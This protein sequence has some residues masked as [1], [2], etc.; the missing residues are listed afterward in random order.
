[1]EKT[2]V[3][4]FELICSIAHTSYH[5]KALS[6]V[7]YNKAQ[8]LNLQAH[9]DELYN[10][11]VRV[12]ASEGY[13]DA[14]VVMLQAHLDM[15]GEK[16]GDT[17]HEFET[18]PIRLVYE[19]NI[20]HADNTTLGADD[21]VGVAYMMALMENKHIKHPELELVFTVQEEVGL[22][23][24]AH[25]DTSHL[26]ATLCIGLDSSGENE[27][28][29]SSSGGVRAKLVKSFKKESL[30]TKTVAIEIL[31]LLGGHSGGDIH[32]ERAN[33]IRLA[34]IILKRSI[35][36]YGIKHVV[37]LDGGLKVNAIPREARL[38]IAVDDVAHYQNW[39]KQIEKELLTQF[40]ISDPN[41]HFIL[42][43]SHTTKVI[44]QKNSMGIANALF[45][46][47]QGVLQKSMAIEDLVI[48]SSNIGIAQTDE[49]SF[50]IYVS[51]R[52]TQ[53]FVIENNMYRVKLIAKNTGY[54]VSFNAKYPGW[55]YEKNSKFRNR[56]FE[57]YQ[58]LR[59]DRMK[60]VA[61]HGGVE[62]GIWKGKMPHLDIIS[63]GPIMYDIHTP[64][65]R[66]DVP[67]FERTFEVLT[68][69]LSSLNI[70]L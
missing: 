10:L 21:G 64:Q 46:L 37:S 53:E 50:T 31:G 4:Y 47:P 58:D 32:L 38:V 45:M 23:G 11:F 22:L 14:P 28:Y 33:A 30:E 60:E 18:D 6:D 67:S 12:P 16:N 36:E 17:Q 39:F 26:K 42:S 29:V 27:V 41:L 8:S 57:V 63:L 44:D 70:P 43:S 34:G 51:L 2:I 13:E 55:N 61:T 1:M 25:F 7:I 56:L 3:E 48:T 15:V 62:L 40:E 54:D 9:Q 68:E 20:L 66:L 19:G 52:A 35:E 24:A 49:E 5:E 69:L 59:N 65:E